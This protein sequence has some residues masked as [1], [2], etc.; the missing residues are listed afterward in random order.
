MWSCGV[1]YHLSWWQCHIEPIFRYWRTG[2]QIWVRW[3]T[4]KAKRMRL[5]LVDGPL[6]TVSVVRTCLVCTPYI[7]VA[8]EVWL[9]HRQN[10]HR[11]HPGPSGFMISRSEFLES[12]LALCL[13][14]SLFPKDWCI[15]RFDTA[16]DMPTFK[17]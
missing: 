10:N 1:R 3:G 17:S 7:C 12:M 4:K 8:D 2:N 6:P 5:S 13:L 11:F 16:S 9:F 14:T 15:W